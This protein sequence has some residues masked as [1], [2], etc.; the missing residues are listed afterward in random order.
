MN[1]LV[2]N[3]IKINLV[4]T[5]CLLHEWQP[6]RGPSPNRI[7]YFVDANPGWLQL[8]VESVIKGRRQADLMKV[9]LE[10]RSG[11]TFSD[12]WHIRKKDGSEDVSDDEQ[13]D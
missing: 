3:N 12:S 9:V 4:M 5:M 7:I 6:K 13:P 8:V 2:E 11:C 1:G 10:T